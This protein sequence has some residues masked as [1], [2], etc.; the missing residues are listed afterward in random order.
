MSLKM[1]IRVG[2]TLLI[3]AGGIIAAPAYAQKI[4]MADTGAPGGSAH[5]RSKVT[6][7]H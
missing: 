7:N 1:E 5:I 6:N 4:Y 3:F 2:A